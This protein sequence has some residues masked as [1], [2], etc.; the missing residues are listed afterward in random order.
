MH[1]RSRVAV[2]SCWA[3]SMSQTAF[4]PA[5]KATAVCSGPVAG[6]AASGM[7]TTQTNKVG[8]TTRMVQSFASSPENLNG[9]SL[10]AIIKQFD[11]QAYETRIPSEQSG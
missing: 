8:K 10:K 4:T 1:T 9:A 6:R 7:N 11:L 5:G 3:S 2:D